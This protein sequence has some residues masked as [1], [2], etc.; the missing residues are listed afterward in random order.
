MQLFCLSLGYSSLSG[1]IKHWVLQS[2]GVTPFPALGPLAP[3]CFKILWIDVFLFYENFY[4][5]KP[6]HSSNV[7]II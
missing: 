6:L 4:Y 7:K 1:H 3:F 5:V 2:R